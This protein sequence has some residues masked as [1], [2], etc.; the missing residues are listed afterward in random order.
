MMN[1]KTPTICH[2]CGQT[3]PTGKM[4]LICNACGN[5]WAEPQKLPMD[6]RAWIKKLN[7]IRCPKCGAGKEQ[8][9][10]PFGTKA[11]AILDDAAG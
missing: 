2:A 1:S 6:M 5:R 7:G 4:P 11:L 9:E 3:M 8:L 10:V